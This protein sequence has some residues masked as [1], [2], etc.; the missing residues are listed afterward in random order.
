MRRAPFFEL[1]Y[2]ALQ[3]IGDFRAAEVPALP[4]QRQQQPVITTQP[5]LGAHA[6]PQPPLPCASSAMQIGGSHSAQSGL[7]SNQ[8]NLFQGN[9]AQGQKV[10]AQGHQSKKGFKTRHKK[11]TGFGG[12]AE[13][14]DYDAATAV[15]P[16][17]Y[18][19]G[20][21][22]AAPSSQPQGRGSFKQSQ[23]GGSRFEPHGGVGGKRAPTV[24]G[25]RNMSFPASKGRM[26]PGRY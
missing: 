20:S 18:S 8:P 10:Q 13:L 7:P 6:Q 15:A 5:S 16:F 12:G 1:L 2:H 24:V 14:Y 25:N 3:E 9:V 21:A 22:A 26:P 19:M 4:Y 23:G 11:R 17:V